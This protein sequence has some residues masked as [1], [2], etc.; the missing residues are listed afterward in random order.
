MRRDM[1]TS[2]EFEAAEAFYTDMFAPGT[3]HVFSIEECTIGVGGTDIYLTGMCF[4]SGLLDGPSTGIYRCRLSDGALAP[5]TP[6]RARMPRL[7]PDGALMA[8]V[9]ESGDGTGEE[10]CILALDGSLATSH[11]I[12]GLIE[13]TQWS[14]DGSRLLLLVAGVGADLA[15]YQGGYAT[16]APH[17]GP[18]WL[19]EVDTGGEGFRW[20]RLWELDAA[21][22]SLRQV[23]CDGTNV[24]EAAWAGPERIAAVCSDDDGEG[25][26]YGANLRI[27]SLQ[28]GAETTVYIPKDQI[29][30]LA[31]SPDGRRIAF[32]EAVCSDRGIICGTLKA[33]E[34]DGVRAL[35]TN[36]V[37]VS[38]I[39]WRSSDVVHYAGQDGFDTVVGDYDFHSASPKEIWRSHELT[40]G[41]WYPAAWP[42]GNEASLVTVEA[43]DRPPAIAVADPSGLRIIRSLA[44][45]A[46]RQAMAGAGHIEPVAWNAAD[47]LEI[48]G[49]LVTPE[50]A[51]QP[52][53]LVLDIHGGPIWASR[54]RWMARGRAAPLLARLGCAVLYANPRGSS[55]RGQDYARLVRGDMGGADAQDLLAGLDHFIVSG[56]ADATRLACTGTSYGGFMSCWLVTQDPRFA[57][58]API[59]PVTDWFSQHRTSQ[60]PH[61]DT[62]FLDDS[63]A[64]PGGRYFFRSPVAFAHHVHTPCVVMTGALDKNTPPTQAEQFHRAL[65]E[66]G[67]ES[68]LVVYPKDGHSLRG[69]P[70]YIDSAARILAWFGR[71]LR[72]PD[73]GQA[74]P[75]R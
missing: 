35:P 46:A 23:S 12:E 6:H 48:Q 27:I 67:I 19:P 34:S 45:P 43:Y 5:V 3:G 17:V 11:R 50:H 54:N 28:G 22:G 18:S 2:K 42:L 26:W 9:M 24:W 4:H 21:S 36:G 60:I 40:C 69:Y 25:S 41:T 39:V 70:A 73:C 75:R 33:I 64:S 14:P 29:G 8:C 44:A 47:G 51:T 32:V 38:G 57:A 37:E 61:F 62:A 74:V 56:L 16:K 52:L 20:R 1:R 7:S 58:A 53:P 15:G 71:H 30:V 59:S 49:W 31:P 13:Q 65:R 55:A 10:L 72:L 63:P 66:S 68:A